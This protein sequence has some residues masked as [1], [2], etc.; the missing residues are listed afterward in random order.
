VVSL[1][2]LWLSWAC[3]MFGVAVFWERG[4][5]PKDS[6]FTRTETVPGVGLEVS[7]AEIHKVQV[8]N[9]GTS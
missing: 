1:D 2:V 3:S 7:L 9:I 6:Y 8:G 5:T 4:A